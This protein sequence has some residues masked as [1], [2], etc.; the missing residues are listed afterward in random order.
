MRS[1]VIV[2]LA[3]AVDPW[4]G[5]AAYQQSSEVITWGTS[6]FALAGAWAGA[7]TRDGLHDA[8]DHASGDVVICVRG[9]VR[10][11]PGACDALVAALRAK[12]DAGL[13]APVVVSGNRATS[14]SVVVDAGYRDEDQRENIHRGVLACQPFLLRDRTVAGIGGGACAFRRRD[15]P[16]LRERLQAANRW[17]ESF[18]RA[19]RCLGMDVVVVGGVRFVVD[20]HS[21]E[22]PASH[23]RCEPAGI[24]TMREDELLVPDSGGRRIA[25]LSPLPPARTG[26]ADYTG[27]LLPAIAAHVVVD[28]F[29][30][31]DT[32]PI[33]EDEVLRRFRVYPMTDFGQRVGSVDY[34]DV[35]YHVGNNGRHT[36]ILDWALRVPGTVVLHEYILAGAAPRLPNETLLTALARVSRRFL[37]HSRH[38]RRLLTRAFPLLRVDVAQHPAK[39]AT[40]A[41]TPSNRPFTVVCAGLIQRHKRIHKVVEAFVRFAKRQPTAKLVL[42]GD[43]QPPSYGEELL[44]MARRGGIQDRV[45]LTGWL[46]RDSF[47]QHI[48][49]ADVIVNL[50]SPIG[51][52]QSGQVARGAGK[53]IPLIV[54]DIDQFRELPGFAAHRVP[55]RDEVRGLVEALG[56]AERRRHLP[57]GHA[58][59]TATIRWAAAEL[60][61]RA[62]ARQYV[63][64][65]PA[66]CCRQVAPSIVVL[67]DVSD[68]R[69]DTAFLAD[70][71]GAAGCDVGVPFST[72]CRIPRHEPILDRLSAWAVSA[73]RDADIAVGALARISEL[74]DTGLPVVVRLTRPPRAEDRAELGRCALVLAATQRIASTVRDL[75]LDVCTATMP[76]VLDYARI[77]SFAAHVQ[78]GHLCM[79]RVLVDTDAGA[80]DS[81]F[82]ALRSL[83]HRVEYL[84]RVGDDEIDLESQWAVACALGQASMATATPAQHVE[85]MPHGVG[86]H[87][88]WRYVAACRSLFH[89]RAMASSRSLVDEATLM[90]MPCLIYEGPLEVSRI[91]SR[92]GELIEQPDRCEA[93][94][95]AARDRLIRSRNDRARAAWLRRELQHL[96]RRRQSGGRAAGPAWRNTR[97]RP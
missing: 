69:D 24:R 11:E 18:S 48:A 40:E 21:P 28:V 33:P 74:L 19:S 9:G 59:R 51:G 49:D 93:A 52:E 64:R 38:T 14:A 73:T 37:V 90:G 80:L 56:R 79:P 22:V 17:E 61:P 44:A 7:A 10:P 13:V 45:S 53:G 50:R 27:L 96:V 92:L 72:L 25:W 23:G 58:D 76:R 5:A 55:Y 60:D 20:R 26:V 3:D 78:G 85:I 8:V 88:H 77:L 82:L 94:M 29:W 6:A 43:A 71:L 47:D 4:I 84:V 81:V 32:G 70:A 57:E 97:T 63:A 46:D 75:G 62:V 16:R 87:T 42:A 65:R 91:R 41:P 39:V 67:P 2:E 36:A 83:P 12:P 35:I 89:C 34:A 66:G 31:T 86:R 95:W 15:W 30:D 54:S 1:S 68:P